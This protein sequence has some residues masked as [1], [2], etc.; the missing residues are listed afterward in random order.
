MV[1][2]TLCGGPV[3]CDNGAGLVKKESSNLARSLMGTRSWKLGVIDVVI[4]FQEKIFK[5]ANLKFLLL[6]RSLQ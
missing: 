1:R 3:E 6:G 2:H 4:L 5:G